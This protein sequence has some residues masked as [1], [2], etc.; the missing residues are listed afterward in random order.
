MPL[1]TAPRQ[2]AVVFLVVELDHFA[3]APHQ[4]VSHGLVSHGEVELVGLEASAAFGAVEARLDETSLIGLP[5]PALV[6]DLVEFSG[7]DP[8]TEDEIELEIEY[9]RRCNQQNSYHTF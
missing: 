4:G 3:A 8:I 7:L 2:P 6:D 9:G 5:D 1:H